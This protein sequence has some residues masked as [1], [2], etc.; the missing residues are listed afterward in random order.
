MT[1][2]PH[3]RNDGSG[4]RSENRPEE[5]F[6]LSPQAVMLEQGACKMVMGAIVRNIGTRMDRP[7][8]SLGRKGLRNLI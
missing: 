1:E 3:G 7:G 2:Q 4:L 8:V 6:R 5:R